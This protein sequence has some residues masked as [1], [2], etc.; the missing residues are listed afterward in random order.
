VSSDDFLW[1]LS[2]AEWTAIGTIVLTAVGAS[3]LIVSALV[4]RHSARSARA[5]EKAAKAASDAV[6]TQLAT[7]EVDFELNLVFNDVDA[8]AAVRLT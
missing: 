3:S 5:A 2:P 6:G 4:A 1:G 7:L 8:P